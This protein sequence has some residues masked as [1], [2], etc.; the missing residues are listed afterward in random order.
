MS[1]KIL[2]VASQCRVKQC[3]IVNTSPKSKSGKLESIYSRK[4][5]PGLQSASKHNPWTRPHASWTQAPAA[6]SSRREKS[7]ETR[8]EEVTLLQRQHRQETER[9]P[10]H[11]KITYFP[12]YFLH[13]T[14]LTHT[15]IW[16]FKVCVLNTLFYVS[17]IWRCEGEVFWLGFAFWIKVLWFWL[18]WAGRQG[19]DN[20]A[21][22]NDPQQQYPPHKDAA[23]SVQFLNFYIDI[24]LSHFK[25]LLSIFLC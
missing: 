13:L 14:I 20:Q 11:F 25:N 2:F 19:K 6:A 8:K 10:R 23:S 3:E 22:H 18:D 24:W 21:T 5:C 7:A 4:A 9:T 15:H 17:H 12:F 1:D 16:S